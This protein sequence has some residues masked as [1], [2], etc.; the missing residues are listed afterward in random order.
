MPQKKHQG[1]PQHPL[2]PTLG[3]LLALECRSLLRGR[4][5]QPASLALL[6]RLRKK[7]WTQR[8]ALRCTD[9]TETEVKRELR[10]ELLNEQLRTQFLNGL[11]DPVRR[12]TLSRDPKNFQ[13]AIDA[14]VREERN[15][16]T[17]NGGRTPVRSVRKARGKLK[18]STHGSKGSNACWNLASRYKMNK[19]SKKT[20]VAATRRDGRLAIRAASV[21]TLLGT[22]GNARPPRANR[23]GTTSQRSHLGSTFTICQEHGPPT[24]T[25]TRIPAP[26]RTALL[27]H[28][29]TAAPH[30]NDFLA[31]RPSASRTTGYQPLNG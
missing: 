1:L 2:M 16:R 17:V 27:E 21:D 26:P 29:H 20:G 4:L 5:P 12:F 30:R 14:A 8:Q 28:V 9:G 25:G 24:P 6:S 23:E 7:P 13:E 15:E 3:P 18:S 10:K 19:C 31:P 22:V 11:R